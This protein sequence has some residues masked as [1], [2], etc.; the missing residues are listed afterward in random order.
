[1]NIAAFLKSKCPII[2]HFSEEKLFGNSIFRLPS[3][4]EHHTKD[5]GLIPYPLDRQ[6]NWGSWVPA[7]RGSPQP[8]LPDSP[9]TRHEPILAKV[10]YHV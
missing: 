6:R 5:V 8:L 3:E 2:K 10:P 4:N 7:C 9:R 1:M